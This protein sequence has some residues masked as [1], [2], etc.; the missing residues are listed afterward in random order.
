MQDVKTALRIIENDNQWNSWQKINLQSL[1]VT[2]AT[3]YQKNKQPNKKS[4]KKT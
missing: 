2:L 1:Q 4:G 3:Q